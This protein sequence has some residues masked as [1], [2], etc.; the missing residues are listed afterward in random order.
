[1]TEKEPILF[2]N[3]CNEQEMFDYLNNNLTP[4]QRHAFELKMEENVFLQEAVEGLEKIQNKQKVHQF[5]T[6]LNHNLDKQLERK[7]IKKHKRKIKTQ[8]W[9]I[10]SIVIIL[11]LCVLGYLVIKQIK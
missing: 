4:Q 8:G 10:I 1:M 7:R 3:D 5:I 11:A 9:I 6:E 2:Q